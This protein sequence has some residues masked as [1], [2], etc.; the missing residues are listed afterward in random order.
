VAGKL[1]EAHGLP[2]LPLSSYLWQR[3]AV[4]AGE[5]DAPNTEESS[6]DQGV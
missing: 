6:D 5:W 1:K 2:A 3:A 4:W